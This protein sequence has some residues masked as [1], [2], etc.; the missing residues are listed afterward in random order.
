M[1][2]NFR[3]IEGGVT[4]QPDCEVRPEP[5][6]TELLASLSGGKAEAFWCLWN[7]HQKGLRRLCLREM[8]GHAADAEDALSRNHVVGIEFS[9]G[10]AG[11]SGL[12]FYCIAVGDGAQN[13]FP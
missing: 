7:R 13:L 10:L 6:D 1:N 9:C 3:K 5:P 2:G 12:V 8:N 4:C 11:E